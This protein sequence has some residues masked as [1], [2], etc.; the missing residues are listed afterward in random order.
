MLD[1]DILYSIIAEVADSPGHAQDLK[2]VSL[3]SPLLREVALPVLFH[4]VRWPH[5]DKHSEENGL[6]FFP[7][8]LWRHFR[9]VY[10]TQ[11]RPGP[12]L[13]VYQ[14]AVAAVA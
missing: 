7:E 5:G 11:G 9:C 12:T 13:T 10:R 14:E 6:E 2:N 8:S 4:D 1:S 3:A